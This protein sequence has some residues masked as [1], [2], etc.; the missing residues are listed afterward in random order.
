MLAVCPASTNG[1]AGR[2]ISREIKTEEIAAMKMGPKFLN[3]EFTPA[4]KR[5]SFILPRKDRLP[6][7]IGCIFFVIF[8]ITFVDV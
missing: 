6:V 7:F 1:G 5:P 3:G 2:S 8:W 4:L